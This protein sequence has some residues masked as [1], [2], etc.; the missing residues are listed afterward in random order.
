MSFDGV[1][2]GSDT[3]PAREFTPPGSPLRRQ[4][5]ITVG[6][7]QPLTERS[8][9]GFIS[10]LVSRV[11]DAEDVLSQYLPP[12][13]PAPKV[14]KVSERIR[15]RAKERESRKRWPGWPRK[16]FSLGSGDQAAPWK[17]YLATPTSSLAESSPLVTGGI[18]HYPTTKHQNA[19]FQRSGAAYWYVGEKPSDTVFSTRNVT[20]DGKLKENRAPSPPPPPPPP[21]PKPP[22]HRPPPPAPSPRSKVLLQH[23]EQKKQA[24]WE[25][26]AADP[27]LDQKPR[28]LEAAAA[29][30][31]PPIIF[32][33]RPPPSS[34]GFGRRESFQRQ[35]HRKAPT[36]PDDPDRVAAFARLAKGLPARHSPRPPRHRAPPAP[37]AVNPKSGKYRK[38][39]PPPPVRSRFDLR[40]LSGL[41]LRRASLGPVETSLSKGSASVAGSRSKARSTDCL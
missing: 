1:T 25:S 4:S 32:Q 15:M 23:G 34:V 29:R 27:Q 26:Q 35:R 19:N 18:L 3:P 37:P 14:M 21:P 2:P 31:A 17:E 5:T 10:A 11:P 7:E 22:A 13:P 30:A 40:A 28:Y 20:K 16:P 33:Q 24:G 36:L 41:R 12:P 8:F 38:P 9:R 39:P 6:E